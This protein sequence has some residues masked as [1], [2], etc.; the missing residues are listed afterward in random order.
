MS[1]PHSL[2]DA[3]KL[4]DK[5]RRID[6]LPEISGLKSSEM[7]VL[8][9]LTLAADKYGL[10]WLKIQ[11]IAKRTKLTDKTIR[12][13][14]KHLEAAKLIRRIRVNQHGGKQGVYFYAVTP[15]Y[16]LSVPKFGNPRVEIPP[17]ITGLKSHRL[18][19]KH[20]ADPIRRF[21]DGLLEQVTPIIDLRQYPRMI[22]V[23]KVSRLIFLQPSDCWERLIEQTQRGVAVLVKELKSTKDLLTSWDLVANLIEPPSAVAA[24]KD[25]TSKGETSQTPSTKPTKPGQDPQTEWANTLPPFQRALYERFNGSQL[26]DSTLLDGLKEMEVDESDTG[27]TITLRRR[28]TFDR[29]SESC[30]RQLQDLASRNHFLIELKCA[31]ARTISIR[32]RDYAHD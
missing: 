29:F 31:G 32:P 20:T 23:Q 6:L 21:E 10:T 2:S 24:P 15:P 22:A 26:L 28:R 3:E 18:N 27:I 12:E 1:K 14:L 9:V 25:D 17:S 5:Y 30:R 19:N 16:G 11:T 13:C 4:Y 8:R 7:F